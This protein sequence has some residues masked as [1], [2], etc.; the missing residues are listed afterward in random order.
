MPGWNG[1]GR[2]LM[3]CKCHTMM[4]EKF[5]QALFDILDPKT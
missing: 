1:E 3:C 2:H 5:V 4:A